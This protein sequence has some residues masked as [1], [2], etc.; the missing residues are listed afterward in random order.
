MC[1]KETKGCPDGKKGCPYYFPDYK[2]EVV[3]SQFLIETIH[4]TGNP[5]KKSHSSSLALPFCS[6]SIDSSSQWPK[7][8]TSTRL[9]MDRSSF[10]VK[11]YV[12]PAKKQTLSLPVP[13]PLM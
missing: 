13:M 12:L 5:T 3:Y 8:T 6:F 10:K 4:N 1:Y 11:R 9:F 2:G 7:K